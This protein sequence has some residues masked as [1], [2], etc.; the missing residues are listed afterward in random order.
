VSTSGWLADARV[1]GLGGPNHDA[2]RRSSLS[3]LLPWAIVGAWAL[4]VLAW[5]KGWS[6]ALGHD[7]L[8]EHG[9]AL[10]V[11]LALF[12]AGWLVMVLAMMLPSSLPAFRSFGALTVVLRN[13]RSLDAAFLAGFIGAWLGFGGLAFLGDI[14]FHRFVHHWQWL[15]QR[16]WL[17]GG[18]VLVIAGAFELS[19]LVGRCVEMSSRASDRPIRNLPLVNSTALRLGMDHGLGRLRRCWPLMLLSFAAGMASLGWMVALTV[20]MVLQEKG[21]GER[22]ALAMGIALLAVA[23]PVLAHPGWMPSLFPG[24]A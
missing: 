6:H 9:P 17:I 13:R 19:P 20:L 18:T 24:A 2:D 7:H 5:A 21:G 15:A 4:V 12:L 1:S 8:I 22:A 16:P 10:W 23:A 14:G 3:V 11:G